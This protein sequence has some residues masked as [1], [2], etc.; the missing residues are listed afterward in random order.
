VV[1]DC[2]RMTRVL[3]VRA[4]DLQWTSS[5]ASSTPR[6]IEAPPVG[7]FFSALAGRQRDWRPSEAWSQQRERHLPV[8]YGGTRDHMRAATVVTVAPSP[9][10]GN[11]AEER[12]G[13]PP[14]WGSS[15]LGGTLG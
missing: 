6:S 10:F 5:R 7:L 11:R 14:S 3:A 15:R 13:L 9:R 8:K 4:G 1:L 2:S 12:V